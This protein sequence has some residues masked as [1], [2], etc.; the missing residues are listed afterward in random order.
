MKTTVFIL[1][2]VL[3]ATCTSACVPLESKDTGEVNDMPLLLNA[4]LEFNE[5]EELISAI[6]D[7][8]DGERPIN[9]G[10][11]AELDF[12]FKPRWIPESARIN[13]IAIRETYCAYQY[14][15]GNPAITD[16]DN[17]NS[18]LIFEWIRGWDPDD[19]TSFFRMQG[20]N[21]DTL[22][23][24]QD[25]Y[26][27]SSKNSTTDSNSIFKTVYWTQ[28][29][30]VFHAEVPISFSDKDVMSFCDAEKVQD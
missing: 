24:T 7:Y 2:L 29:D 5:T 18:R 4:P 19:V 8:K 17:P 6:R 15:L 9:S 13:K 22:K 14:I 1:V 11:L 25:Y 27:I 26:V 30:L 23:G 20:I 12:F 3:L 10:A 21:Y 16:I 28:H